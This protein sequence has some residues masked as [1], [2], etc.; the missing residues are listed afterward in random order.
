MNEIR[1]CDVFISY[2]EDSGSGA[3][4][5]L[6]DAI[7]R[8]DLQPFAFEYTLAS[9]RSWDKQVLDALHYSRCVLVLVPTRE[10]RLTDYMNHEIGIAHV[11]KKTIVPV[12]LGDDFSSSAPMSDML[13]QYW[14]RPLNQLLSNLDSFLRDLGIDMA[15]RRTSVWSRYLVSDSARIVVGSIDP[16]KLNDPGQVFVGDYLSIGNSRSVARLLCFFSQEFGAD[17]A[18]KLLIARDLNDGDISR[19]DLIVLGGPHSLHASPLQAY[20]EQLGIRF[21]DAQRAYLVGSRQRRIA[22]EPGSNGVKRQGCVLCF[23]RNPMNRQREILLVSG[24]S[25]YGCQGAIEYLVGTQIDPKLAEMVDRWRGGLRD[26]PLLFE[27]STEFKG[28][29]CVAGSAVARLIES[30]PAA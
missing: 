4:K 29:T 24:V 3:A 23:A 15:A 10:K 11:L 16:R 1:P 30:D 6:A 8:K 13:S 5:Q 19:H 12:A 28:H 25:G 27:I 21:D 17:F 20:H 26:I 14:G 7:E 2:S 22:T 9:G 18:D